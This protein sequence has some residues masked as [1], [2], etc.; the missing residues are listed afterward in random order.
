M[1]W[2]VTERLAARRGCIRQDHNKSYYQK[3]PLREHML[4]GALQ[5][6][7]ALLLAGYHREWAND[8]AISGRQREF[9]DYV[10][11][12]SGTRIWISERALRWCRRV[13]HARSEEIIDAWYVE[14][15]WAWRMSKDSD[16]DTQRLAE[17]WYRKAMTDT[18]VAF[19]DFAT[20]YAANPV[21]V[22]NDHLPPT[23]KSSTS[24]V[25]TWEAVLYA[26]IGAKPPVRP[27]FFGSAQ[28]I[29][30][31]LLAASPDPERVFALIDNT[32]IAEEAARE[33]TSRQINAFLRFEVTLSVSSLD[34]AVKCGLNAAQVN[35]AEMLFPMWLS[36]YGS[37]D[38]NVILAFTKWLQ[39]LP[40]PAI[41]P[42]ADELREQ[43]RR[44]FRYHVDNILSSMPVDYK[45]LFIEVGTGGYD[46]P[47]ETDGEIFAAWVK[48]IESGEIEPP[49]TYDERRE[50]AIRLQRLH[51]PDD[52]Q[53]KIPPPSARQIIQ[54]LC[55]EY[56][57]HLTWLLA[58]IRQRIIG[59][60]V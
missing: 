5:S 42:V 60:K 31:R 50:R 30:D 4:S 44:D 6:G 47:T 59:K 12:R 43:R 13:H 34:L 38:G 9:P 1:T 18:T 48:G 16:G 19:R 15:A 22:Q 8:V 40:P 37:P 53:D 36:V 23:A 55:S 51:V 11:R 7:H 57:M 24:D 56:A 52:Y 25:K 3:K 39:H 28:A 58:R 2:S 33:L 45:N 14:C 32:I 17:L 21:S 54:R 27:I 29:L 20:R 49:P 10:A 26:P 46:A 35:A 41:E